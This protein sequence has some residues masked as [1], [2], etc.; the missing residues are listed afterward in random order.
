VLNVRAESLRNH[1]E[2]FCSKKYTTLLN[3]NKKELKDALFLFVKSA[4]SEYI[5]AASALATEKELEQIRAAELKLNEPLTEGGGDKAESEAGCFD[6]AKTQGKKTS[7]YS[8]L[9]E[10]DLL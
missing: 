9:S 4:M 8:H 1:L 5:D 10:E 3:L 2:T 7:N 6:T